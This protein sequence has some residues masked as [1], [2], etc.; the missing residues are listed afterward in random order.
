[1]QW[2]KTRVS[3]T[4]QLWGLGYYEFG[5]YYVLNI[6]Q[7]NI[8]IHGSP[9]FL[10]EWGKHSW[11]IAAASPIKADDARRAAAAAAA[12]RLRPALNVTEQI[13]GLERI[14]MD[15]RSGCGQPICGS[16]DLG[17]IP[18]PLKEVAT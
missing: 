12:P 5:R 3:V 1:M 18:E 6:N 8:T 4:E 17:V 15:A 16:A 2:S 9:S 14:N 10:Q 11:D 7:D 13:G